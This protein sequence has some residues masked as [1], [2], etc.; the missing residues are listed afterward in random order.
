MTGFKITHAR[1]CM[2]MCMCMCVCV[3][4]CV[5]VCVCGWV[6]VWGR[7]QT[8]NLVVTVWAHTIV[9]ML[10][11]KEGKIIGN[12]RIGLLILWQNSNWV[13]RLCMIRLRLPIM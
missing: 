7:L 2:C 5:G 4:V 13:I 8:Q 1:V 3:C 12:L 10:I 9:Y 11:V 6:C